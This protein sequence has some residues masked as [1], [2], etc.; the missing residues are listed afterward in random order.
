MTRTLQRTSCALLATLCLAAAAHAAPPKRTVIQPE[1][2]MPPDD[3]IVR[4][5]HYMLARWFVL[6]QETLDLKAGMKWNEIVH[7]E[8]RGID[9]ADPNLD[10]ASSE[11]WIAVDETSCTLITLP[12]ITNRYYTVQ[13]LNGWGEV[14]ANLNERNYPKH[15]YGTFA[16]CLRG[17]NV[18]LPAGAE[19]VDLPSR[20]S[21]VLARIELGA[22]PQQ[23]R[24][25]QKQITMRATGTPKIAP[26]AAVM[27][28][29]NDKLPGIAAFTPTNVIL[30]SDPDVNPGMDEAF[31]TARAMDEYAHDPSYRVKIDKV[32]TAKA[33]PSFYEAAHRPGEERNG[34]MRP[35]AAGSYGSDFL[36]RSVANMT[37]IW[38]NTPQEMVDFSRRNLDGSR[39]YT[40][41]FSKEALPKS[42][43][44]YFWSVAAVDSVR[45]RVIPNARNRHVLHEQSKPTL[46]ADGSLTLAFGPTAPAG[47]P[48]SNWLPTAAGRAY[49]L[50]FRFYGPTDDVV[51]G[52]YYP[53]PLVEQ[54]AAD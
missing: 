48:E 8:P 39:T 27:R 34:W 10:V 50:T 32:I 6:R 7:R 1:V 19:R 24:A 54:K 53:P 37:D 22:D 40:Q 51:K 14:T 29:T 17:A 41:T 33:I 43:V 13:V 36:M 46:N 38:A 25:L 49:D 42:K 30:A 18:K 3:D 20:K 11:A 31:A 44:K 45:H 16:L 21:R 15:P 2:I 28:F 47:V 9:A 4:A 35:R 26:T 23:A 12:E 52:T 5:Y